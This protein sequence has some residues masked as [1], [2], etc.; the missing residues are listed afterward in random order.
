MAVTLETWSCEEVC[1]VMLF[2]WVKHFSPFGIYHRLLEACGDGVVSVHHVGNWFREIENGQKN[3]CDG[4]LTGWPR[5]SRT[6]V[7][8]SQVEELILD[9]E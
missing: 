4:D 5:T 8:A 7:N 2:L 3:I 1:N 9:S 6:D